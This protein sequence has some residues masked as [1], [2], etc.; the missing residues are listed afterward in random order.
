MSDVNACKPKAEAKTDK[1]KQKEIYQRWY[2]KMMADPVR[3]AKFLERCH[4]NQKAQVK[5]LDFQERMRAYSR[6]YY[7]RSR[8]L[9]GGVERDREKCRR[10][11]ARRKADPIRYNHRKEYAKEYRKKH[12]A[13]PMWVVKSH[14][15]G[16]LSDLVRTGAARKSK[17][18]LTLVGCTLQ[19]FYKHIERQFKKGMNWKN[20][21]AVWHIDHIIPCS[22]FNLIDPRQQVICFNYLNLRPCWAKEN[23]R[24]NARIIKPSQLPLGI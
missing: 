21:G 7:R 6:A 10:T 23:L 11:A 17:S 15:R 24:K 4:R 13:D 19:E 14:L 12:K 8:A 1:V 3:K 22:K 16:R 5:D 2:Q 18:A 20:H 9:P